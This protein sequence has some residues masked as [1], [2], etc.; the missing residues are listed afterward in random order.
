MAGHLFSLL[1]GVTFILVSLLQQQF[2]ATFPAG[3]TSHTAVFGCMY[4][5]KDSSRAARHAQKWQ[6]LLKGV[7]AFSEI[8]WFSSTHFFSFTALLLASAEF[9]FFGISS[10]W[11][12]FFRCTTVWMVMLHPKNQI[13]QVSQRQSCF[14]L[15]NLFSSFKA[16]ESGLTQRMFN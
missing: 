14:G 11:Q 5:F 16:S 7:L 3:E 8:D 2:F 1:T 12:S 6:L 9:Q 13:Y 15:P 10:L 4:S